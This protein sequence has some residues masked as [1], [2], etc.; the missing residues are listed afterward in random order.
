MPTALRRIRDFGVALLAIVALVYVVMSVS[1]EAGQDGL[2]S[3][4]DT[5][6]APG[7]S[8]P[9]PAKTEPGIGVE[10][11]VYGHTLLIGPIEGLT[12]GSHVAPSDTFMPLGTVVLFMYSA[13]PEETVTWTGAVEIDRDEL[14]STAMCSFVEL[15]LSIVEVESSDASGN[16]W[17]SR[18]AVTVVDVA[19][20]SIEVGLVEPWADPLE[21]DETLPQDQLNQVTMGYFF[22]SSIAALSDLGNGRSTYFMVAIW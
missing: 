1:L 5:T 15:G 11:G 12:A 9:G 19:V 4:Q 7:A 20:E 10:P 17:S 8:L 2:R 6:K 18:S 13:P 14:G 21:I 3:P 16:Q 22:G